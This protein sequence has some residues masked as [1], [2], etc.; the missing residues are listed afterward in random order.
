M[1]SSSTTAGSAMIGG[2]FQEMLRC[3][4][5]AACLNQ[6]PVYAAIGGHA[7]GWVYP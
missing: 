7:Y 3:L 1:S 5:C 4:R 6:C 2:E